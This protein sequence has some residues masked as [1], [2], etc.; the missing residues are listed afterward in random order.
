M[1]PYMFE[2]THMVGHAV[3]LDERKERVVFHLEPEAPQVRV[4]GQDGSVGAGRGI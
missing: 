1:W 3:H 4:G 2:S